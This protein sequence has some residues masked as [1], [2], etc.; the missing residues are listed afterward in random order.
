MIFVGIDLSITSTGVCLINEQNGTP[1]YFNVS[2]DF[3]PSSKAFRLHND[4]IEQGVVI[5]S[6]ESHKVEDYSENEIQKTLN[7]NRI[8]KIIL[9]YI[10]DLSAENLQ[11]AI[12]G[13]SYGSKGK[14][15]IDLINY[16][17]VLR[18]F[19]LTKAVKDE[20]LSIISPSAIKKFASGKGNASKH[21]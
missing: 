18:H 14:S 3:K 4:L 16:Q 5:D 17:S 21:V 15:Y 19:L 6:Y 20:A 1:C 7:A 10:K 13:F 9:G 8:C 12:E 11:V 2:R